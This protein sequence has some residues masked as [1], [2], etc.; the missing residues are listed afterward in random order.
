MGA[1]SG[2]NNWWQRRDLNLRPRAYESSHYVKTLKEITQVTGV[3]WFASFSQVSESYLSQVKN[4]RIPPSLKL[5]RAIHAYQVSHRTQHDYYDSF[6]ASRDT[7]GVTP[8]SLIY[9]Q[10]K[11]R[12]FLF[13]VNADAAKK[14]DIE[15]FL[16]QFSNLGNR[17]CFYRVIKTFFNWR[18][19]TYDVPS[20]MKKLRAPRQEKLIMPSLT[21]EQVNTLLEATEQTRD[22]AI[23]TMFV[24]SGLRLSELINLHL[25]DFDWEYRTVKVYGKGRKEALAPFGPRAERYVKAWL[26]EYKPGKDPIWGVNQWG[27]I[28][29]L[30]RLEQR[31]GLP[32]NPHT[33]RRTFACILRKSGLDVM[34]IKD[35]GRWESLEMVQRYTRSVNFHDS[36]KF[37][38]GVFPEE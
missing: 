2:L 38:H 30:R 33:F 4:G 13:E 3:A 28:S 37:Y 14:E 6:L 15:Q 20:P 25:Y 32:C 11:V 5:K 19:D 18:E 8:Q 31:T 27:I 36:L 29:M 35:L 9:Y 7:M 22:K 34:T 26:D 16:V 17:S 12:R 21:A 24:E 10:N 1:Q 23:I